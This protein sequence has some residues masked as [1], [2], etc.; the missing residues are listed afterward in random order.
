MLFIIQGDKIF[1]YVICRFRELNSEYFYDELKIIYLCLEA[2]KT[3]IVVG[4]NKSQC[5]LMKVVDLIV[6]CS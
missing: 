3:M 1:N 4:I 2:H 6:Q 5:P